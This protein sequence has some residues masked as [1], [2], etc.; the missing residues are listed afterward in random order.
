MTDGLWILEVT[1]GPPLAQRIIMGCQCVPFLLPLSLWPLPRNSGIDLLPFILSVAISSLFCGHLVS[2]SKYY[3]SFLAIAPISLGSGSGLMYSLETNIPESHTIGFQI[4]AGIGTGLGMQNSLLA[5]QVEFRD[6]PALVGQA[7]SL[8]SF[9]QAR[10]VSLLR[11]IILVIYLIS[12]CV[13]KFL[14]WT[15]A[16]G[17]VEPS[18][19]YQL[20]K[21]LRQYAPDVPLSVVQ[22]PPTSIY[23]A[24]PAAMVPGVMRAYTASFENC[25]PH[26]CVAFLALFSDA[27]I[28]NRRIVQAASP[29][30]K[31]EV[32]SAES[33]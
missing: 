22:Q 15:L 1:P 19:A 30:A 23:S 17:V 27:F 32:E 3:W 28:N 18:C 12:I 31:K 7:T 10:P 33:V 14:G 16:L 24:L 29:A 25:V 11:I 6:A 20:S 13:I 9:A 8:G 21:Y 2:L 4:L 26:R 5:L